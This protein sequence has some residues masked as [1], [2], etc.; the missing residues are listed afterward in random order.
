[1]RHLQD[2]PLLR[3]PSFRLRF[4]DSLKTRKNLIK[5]QTS[6]IRLDLQ[7]SH[8]VMTRKKRDPRTKQN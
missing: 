2:S 3:L 8:K 5:K 1:M 7:D 6:P 4:A